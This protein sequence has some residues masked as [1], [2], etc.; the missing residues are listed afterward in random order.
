MQLV[1]HTFGLSAVRVELS[2][3]RLEPGSYKR[4]NFHLKSIKSA[5]HTG[6]H[7]MM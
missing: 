1:C 6:I 3:F 7:F 5:Q 2:A 4:Q